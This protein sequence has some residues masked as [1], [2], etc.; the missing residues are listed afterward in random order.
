MG[1]KRKTSRGTGGS[2]ARTLH[3]HR[4]PY[5]CSIPKHLGVMMICATSNS[6]ACKL[7]RFRQRRHQKGRRKGHVSHKN[8]VLLCRAVG[9]ALPNTGEHMI[10]AISCLV[11][12]CLLHTRPAI[13][14]SS[15]ATLLIPHFLPALLTPPTHTAVGAA[16]PPL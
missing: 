16:A 14:V 10:Y 9:C 5:L 11:F 15:I 4:A 3:A 13:L 6:A 1:P 8:Y 12:S 7:R 2:C